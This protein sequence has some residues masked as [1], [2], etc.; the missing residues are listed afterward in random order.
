MNHGW[1]A[2]PPLRSLGGQLL[3]VGGLLL[4]TTLV[5]ITM[6]VLRGEFE[7]HGHEQWRILGSDLY[8][9][10]DTLAQGRSIDGAAT[11]LTSDQRDRLYEH[12]MGGQVAPADQAR[13]AEGLCRLDGGHQLERARRTLLIGDPAQRLLAARFLTHHPDPAARLLVEQATSA[14]DRRRERELAQELRT[15]LQHW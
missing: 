13:Y 12:W 14:A 4:I 10:A 11:A 6:L 8:G 15:L 7:R 3:L 9:V 2:L 5:A 1:S